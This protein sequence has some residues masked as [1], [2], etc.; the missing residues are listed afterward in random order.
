V[1]EPTTTAMS[2]GDGY[3]Y[4][5]ST[6]VLEGIRDYQP[7]NKE[8]WEEMRSIVH[9]AVLAGRPANWHSGA[10]MARAA[11]DLILWATEFAFTDFETRE[12]FTERMARRYLEQLRPRVDD[13]RHSRWGRYIARMVEGVTGSAMTVAPLERRDPAPYLRA[14]ITELLSTA[15]A[16]RTDA[17][18]EIALLEIALGAG[19]GLTLVEME[20]LRVRD[21]QL[22]FVHVHGGDSPRVV[23][24]L[25]RW[26]AYLA[27]EGRDP[28]EFVFTPHLARYAKRGRRMQLTQRDLL[29]VGGPDSP[30][31]RATWTAELLQGGASALS[32]LEMSGHQTFQVFDRFRKWM[33]PPT[34]STNLAFVDSLAEVAR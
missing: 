23:P 12:I 20:V 6:E 11:C 9:E 16:M 15:S 14:E 22:P 33:T 2:E 8:H 28:D 19:A 3:I 26:R 17:Q 1:S 18:R 25:P 24:V 21:V 5:H 30:R 32:L 29:A 4:N 27:L 31:L 7:R 10:Q 13:G 34:P